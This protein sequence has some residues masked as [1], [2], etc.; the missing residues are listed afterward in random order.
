MDKWK[1]CRV[2]RSL[3]K[4]HSGQP[5]QEKLKGKTASVQ[6]KIE[7]TPSSIVQKL[8][9]QVDTSRESFFFRDL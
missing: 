4:Q 6:L 1:A 2:V 8:S 9:A 5:L 7:D 3:N